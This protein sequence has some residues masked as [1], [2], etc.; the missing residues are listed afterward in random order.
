[1][2]VGSQEHARGIGI[3]VEPIRTLC[4]RALALVCTPAEIAAAAEGGESPISAAWP[5]VH[6]SAK[7][8][9]YKAFHTVTGRRLAFHDVEV[10]LRPG[11]Y[12]FGVSLADR[13]G[14]GSWT[15]FGRFGI[16]DS[17]VVTGVTIAADASSPDSPQGVRD[18]VVNLT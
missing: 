18:S 5:I 1:V 3:D 13:I 8:S 7:E 10:T 9:V 17:H 16:H 11:A 2:V 15:L 4:E 12:A 14:A 6:F